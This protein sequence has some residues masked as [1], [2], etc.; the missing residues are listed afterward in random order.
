MDEK[1]M[2]NLFLKVSWKSTN[3]ISNRSRKEN[4][5]T[6][7]QTY[8]SAEHGWVDRRD[9]ESFTLPQPVS[10]TASQVLKS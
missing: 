7:H 2:H 6:R 9:K 1:N 4:K 8:F 5:T 10:T 3:K